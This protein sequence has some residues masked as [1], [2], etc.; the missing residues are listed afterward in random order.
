MC[1]GE[2]SPREKDKLGGLHFHGM[3][4]CQILV[5]LR[6]Y[7]VG[8]VSALP[9]PHSDVCEFYGPLC[10]KPRGWEKIGVLS[11]EGC[12]RFIVAHDHCW[13]GSASPAQPLQAVP[14]TLTAGVSQTSGQEEQSTLLEAC[15]STSESAR[16]HPGG[17]STPWAS[18]Q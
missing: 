18:N 4:L 8:R 11:F 6:P 14:H 2:A 13:W 7:T 12:W 16:D 10:H 9:A 1:S 3:G 17:S 15:I 5:F